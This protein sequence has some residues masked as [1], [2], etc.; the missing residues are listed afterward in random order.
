MPE[1]LEFYEQIRYQTCHNLSRIQPEILS[2]AVP[3]CKNLKE[4]RAIRTNFAYHVEATV[5]FLKY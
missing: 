1:Y 5:V 3:E 2:M 4:T